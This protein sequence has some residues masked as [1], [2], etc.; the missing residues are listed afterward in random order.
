[1]N[2]VKKR[3]CLCILMVGMVAGSAKS[4][5]FKQVAYI[6][7]GIVW[8]S[9]YIKGIDA[10]NDGYEDLIFRTYLGQW[11]GTVFWGYRPYNRYIFEDSVT[12]PLF[13]EIG[14]LDSDSLLDMITQYADT[15]S[16][17]HFI[18]VY[19]P[20]NQYAFPKIPVWSWRYEWV[21]NTAENIYITD[22]DRDGQKEFITKDN[23]VIY[24]FENRGNN[25]YQMVFSDTLPGSLFVPTAP[26]AIGDFDGDGRMEFVTGVC[27]PPPSCYLYEC[28][29]DDQYQITWTDTIDA[30]N[31]YDAITG[32]DLD[33]DGKFEFIFG[34]NHL[35]AFRWTGGLWIYEASG[36][37]QYELS[38][39]DSVTGLSDRG[40]YCVHSDCGDVDRDG[41]PELVWAIDRDWMV[42][43]NQS[44]IV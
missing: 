13:W 38:Y 8:S 14:Y 12:W 39:T 16:S 35:G 17:D 42:Y 24:V 43:I 3:I 28:T 34:D 21:G 31:M 25:Q 15:S 7:S 2:K 18:Y 30:Y 27:T 19:E 5:N 26:F 40:V 9:G 37:N 10:N 32:P 4:L 1:V 41:K 29:G 22:L 44:I 11:Q 33:G 23:Q 36:N 6:P 20:P